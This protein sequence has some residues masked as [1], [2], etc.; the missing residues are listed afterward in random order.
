MNSTYINDNLSSLY[1]FTADV[2][3]PFPLYCIAGCG[4]CFVR[5][6]NEVPW[7]NVYMV[8]LQISQDG[9][10]AVLA[11][12]TET[13]VTVF[14]S[15]GSSEVS[16]ARTA[17]WAAMG[18]IVPGRVDPSVHGTYAGKWRLSDDVVTYLEKGQWANTEKMTVNGE[19]HLVPQTLSLEF[20]GFYGFNGNKLVGS[21]P[22]G[23]VT[24]AQ[25]VVYQYP[26]VTKLNNIETRKSSSFYST[27]EMKLG[28]GIE[29]SIV[30]AH[31]LSDISS[32]ASGGEPRTQFSPYLF[33]DFSDTV[34]VTVNGTAWDEQNNT[35]VP[36][37]YGGDDDAALDVL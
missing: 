24:A 20:G 23:A 12:D 34:I 3:V 27:L 17:N 37:C 13:L 31:R 10:V 32:S 5:F 25:D 19:A 2:K 33:T 30:N 18:Y 4:V 36:S 11:D 29:A 8:S 21:V 26:K 15:E 35:G 7:P 6:T 9:M 16:F 1:P 22:E 14:W 28:D